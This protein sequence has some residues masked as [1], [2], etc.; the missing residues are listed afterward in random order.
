MNSCFRGEQD[1]GDGETQRSF[2]FYF[3]NEY[4]LTLW[5]KVIVIANAHIY[6]RTKILQTM[7]LEYVRIYAMKRYS[8]IKK[9]V[10][11]RVQITLT[12]FSMLIYYIVVV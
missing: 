9:C 6:V 3:G 8:V 4:A 11:W 1:G 10:F 12:C 5:K 2:S 7:P